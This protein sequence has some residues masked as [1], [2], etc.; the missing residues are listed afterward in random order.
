MIRTI[1]KVYAR[2]VRRLLRVPSAW[3]IVVGIIVTPSLYA[4][5]NIVGFWDPYGN[6]GNLHVSVVNLD[7]GATS[8]LTGDLDVGAQVIDQ[9]HENHELDWHFLDDEASA[10]ASVERGESYAAIIIPADFSANLLSITSGD[11]QQPKFTYLVNEKANAVAPKVT[12]VGAS[13]IDAQITSSF[14]ASVAKSVA[15]ALSKAGH[16]LE[17][18]LDDAQNDTLAAVDEASRDLDSAASGIA[19][20]QAD[21][22]ASHERIA[23]A[24]GLLDDVDSALGDL[25]TGIGQTQQLVGDAQRDTIAFTDSITQVFV[26]S[27]S[28]LADT[29]AEANTAVAGLTSGVATANGRV[30][31]ALGVAQEVAGENATALDALQRL[32]DEGSL[33]DATKARLN[34]VIDDLSTQNENH[35]D[36]LDRLQDLNGAAGDTNT[37]IANASDSINDAIQGTA[38][39]AAT[40]R[41]ILVDTIPALTSGMADLSA[42]ASDLSG[43]ITARR[44]EVAQAQGLLDQLDT[45]MTTASAALDGVNTTVDGLQGDLDT[46]RTDIL[47]LS[48]AAEWN[49]IGTLTGL[50]ADSIAAFMA[51]PVNVSEQVV[52]PIATYGSAMSALFTNLSL[53]IGAFVL[54]VII[55]LEVD[56]EGFDQ[57]SPTESYLSRWLL[58]AGFSVLQAIL[59][60][61]G[62]LIIGVQ[63]VNAAAFVA[64]GVVVALA[65][66]SIIYALSVTFAHIGKGLCV[67]LVIMQIPGAS[68]LYPIEMMPDFFRAMYPL[69]PFTY[70]IDAMRE[71]IAGFY[72]AH[73]WRAL[74]ALGVFVIAAFTL[75]LVLRRRLVNLA[76]LFSRETLRTDLIVGESVQLEGSPYRLSQVL[77]ALSNQEDYRQGLQHRARA[78]ERNYP[79]LLHIALWVGLIVP[80]VLGVVSSL[81]TDAKAAVLGMWVAWCLVIIGFLVTIEYIRDSIHRQLEVGH[82]GEKGLRRAMVEIASER[83]FARRGPR[84]AKHSA[85]DDAGEGSGG[86]HADRA[87][88]GSPGEPGTPAE[89]GGPDRSGR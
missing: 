23:A 40:M 17:S 44:S 56:H 49:T 69:F 19:G 50:D 89:S 33:D 72:D 39:V 86:A 81:T 75:G 25:Q 48:G 35:Q 83:L 70:G 31:D 52:F 1:G 85:D 57:L 79:R 32:V 16:E 11:F 55:R 26:E 63:T 20:M 21:I 67:V 28:M 38:V 5:F 82:L 47:A 87:T 18:G 73:Y 78:F 12:D 43:T 36:T 14:T 10:R 84:D 74:A 62:D 64:T 15:E 77:R 46:V 53:W 60:C 61:V 13:T 58:L 27:S 37:S 24:R 3:I 2:D 45:Q 4:W 6:T 42:T 65:Y 9:L 68:G 22:A 34:E 76:R 54:V 8:D 88:A 66:H 59:V 41:Q 51:S 30:G 71:T 29:S 7:A 80:I